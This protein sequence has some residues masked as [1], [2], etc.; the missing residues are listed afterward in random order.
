MTRRHDV[1]GIGLAV[2]DLS[3]L[4]DGF[5]EP[6]TKVDAVEHWHGGGGPVPNAMVTL[7]RW[8]MHVAYVGRVGDDLWGR[9]LRDAFVAAGVDVSYLELDPELT[10]PVASL[11][12]DRKSA[13]RTAV[14]GGMHYG[15]PRGLPAGIIENAGMLH[16]DARDPQ[17]C[18]E[19]AR[20]ARNSG[21]PVSLDVGS[22]RLDV[23]P[24]LPQASHLVVAERFAAAVTGQDTVDRMLDGLWRDDYEAAVITRGAG[25]ALGRARGMPRVEC[26]AF[27]VKAVDTTGAGDIYHAGYI[28]GALDGWSL[29]RRMRFAAAAGALAATELGARGM[30]PTLQEVQALLHQ[31]PETAGG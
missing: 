21:V 19:A 12:V 7:A 20:R 14:L 5:P 18:L 27:A 1:V 31:I 6:D 13:A 24:V 16:L 23:K 17:L 29:L 15:Q 25:G 9:A 2:Y 11:W 4:V 28:Y 3:F 26:G 22:P 10:T 30:L 8:G